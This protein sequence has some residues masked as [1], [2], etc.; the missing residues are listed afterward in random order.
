MKLCLLT[1]SAFQ[2]PERGHPGQPGQ[3]PEGRQGSCRHVRRARSCGR[4]HVEGAVHRLHRPPCLLPYCLLCICVANHVLVA[5]CHT[6]CSVLFWFLPL[7]SHRQ[8]K[9]PAMWAKKSYPSLKPLGSYVNDLLAR[10]RFLQSW[11]VVCMCLSCLV[12]SVCLLVHFPR[13]TDAAGMTRVCRL[14]SGCLDS[15]SP[16][17]GSETRIL[18]CTVL[19]PNPP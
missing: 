11:S 19:S 4:R 6:C 17:C 10:L 15:T 5:M 18:T 12:L 9:I 7:P 3:H 13:S 2:P 14:C 1:H 8:G 16:R